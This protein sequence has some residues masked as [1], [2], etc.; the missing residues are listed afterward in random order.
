[1]KLDVDTVPLVG[2][3]SIGRTNSDADTG[4]L[5]LLASPDPLSGNNEKKKEERFGI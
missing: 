1:M 4:T 3:L 5:P 2:R